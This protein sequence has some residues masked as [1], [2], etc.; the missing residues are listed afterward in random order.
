MSSL[1][2]AT[3]ADAAAIVALVERCYRGEA[4]RAGWTT[5]A[6][7][8]DGHR[9][10]LQEILRALATPNTSIWLLD[11]VEEGVLGSVRLDFDPRD[12]SVLLGMFAIEPTRQNQQLGRKVLAAAE[13][14]MR[15]LGATLGRMH[16]LVQ[17][18]ELLAWY[19]RRGWRQT[20]THVPFPY[21]EPHHG[22]PRRDDLEFVV[23]EKPLV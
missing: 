1:R 22:L 16:V 2:R 11:G 12:A 5:E 6:D 8:L 10:D 18:H 14:R 23:L 3:S 17:R 21:D 13:D 4:S 7:L 20:T 19:V 9:T 15:A